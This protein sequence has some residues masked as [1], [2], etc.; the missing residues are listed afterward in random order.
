[1]A[2]HD[3]PELSELSVVEPVREWIEYLRAVGEPDVPVRLPG[4]EAL[5]G[6]LLDLAVPHEDVDPLL[7]WLPDPAS[8]PHAWWLLERCVTGL[9][10]VM[11]DV[12]RIPPLPNLP[13][14]LG[15]LA[16]YLPVYAFIAALPALNEYY[17]ERGI[18]E[19]VREATL[20]DLGRNMAVTRRRNGTGGLETAF[21]LVRHFKGTIF[22]L[23]RLQFERAP[24]GRR[25]RAAIVAAGL[26]IPAP[27]ALALAVHIPEFSGP[28]DAPA[29]DRSF[30]QAPGFFGRH[31][32]DEQFPVAV[33]C[34][35]LLDSQLAEYLPAESNIIRFQRR[36]RPTYRP[37]VNDRDIQLFV[38]GQAPESPA[39]LPRTT[40][41]ERA[42]GD[43]LR[44][45]RHWYGGYGWFPLS[46]RDQ[47]VTPESDL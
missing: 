39:S 28:L 14:H 22:Q 16:R 31:F 21:W 43:H 33:C 38:F 10:Q 42:I 45:G 17:E 30:D 3:L 41:L 44:A 34:S 20:R 29:C 37:E 6:L 26:P 46:E 24:L 47:S 23:G 5:P 27:D 4:R 8:T 12:H 15:P 11:G 25:T 18:P 9:R 19:P 2:A 32:A 40:R 1:M 7:A 35:W 36:F 13:Q